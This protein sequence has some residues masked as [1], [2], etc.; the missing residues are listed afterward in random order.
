MFDLDLLKSVTVPQLLKRVC[1]Q[2]GS[3]PAFYSYGNGNW[4]S[5]T[6]REVTGAVEGIAS[7]LLSLVFSR[8]SKI[9][10]LSKN[11]PGWCL[12]Y[13]GILSMG[14]TAVPLDPLLKANELANIINHSESEALFVSAESLDTL[15]KLSGLGISFKS[16]I[17]LDEEQAVSDR[18]PLTQLIEKGRITESRLPASSNLDLAV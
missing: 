2:Y 1:E 17:V 18:I 15:E 13:L 5:L 16:V 11:S 4:A 10:I 3:K 6:Y 7:G 14:G 9:A 12:A 8:T